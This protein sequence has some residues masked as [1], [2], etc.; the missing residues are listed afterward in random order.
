MALI[1]PFRALRPPKS[2]AEKVAALPYDV[3]NVEEAKAMAAGNPYSFLHVSRPE[4]DLPAEVDPYAEEVYVKGRENMQ[5]FIAEGTLILDRDECYY[6][7]R[8]RMGAIEQTGL[9]VC[10]GVD[11][12]ES[13]VIKKHE[14]TRADKEEDR[15]R[16]IDYLDANDEPVFYTY[17]NDP[18]ITAIVAGVAAG[19]PTYHFTTDD[20]VIH[21]LWIISDRAVIDDLTTRFAAI[22]TLY[23]ADGHHRSAAAGRVRELRR[24]ANPG[25]TGNEEYNWFLTVIFPDSEMNIMPYNRAVKDLNGHSVAELMARIGERFAITPAAGGFAPSQR[26]EFGMYLEGRWYQLVAREGTFDEGDAVSHLD[27]SILQNN[28]LS[29]IL[30]IRNPRT[31]QRISFVGGI[32]GTDELE[33]LV[34]GGG[35]RIAFSLNPTSME[36]LM[37]LADAGQIMPPKST[38]FEP[39]LRSGL[40]V[41]QLS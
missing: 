25:H 13:G 1:K 23:V 38:W 11:D 6:V 21:T 29:P 40:F 33:R 15:V 31:D 14:L 36:E 18:A 12:Y 32:R 2:L 10:A 41:H 9:V 39:K 26:H 24:A 27:V 34:D 22:K 16:H 28:L 19:E 4:I 5:R 35:Y 17:R 3:M 20:G 8:Q 30:A 37:Q 7:Y